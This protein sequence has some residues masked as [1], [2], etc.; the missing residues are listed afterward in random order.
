M[1]QKVTTVATCCWRPWKLLLNQ[2]RHPFE[3]KV[4]TTVAQV[5]ETLTLFHATNIIYTGRYS[6][7]ADA[8]YCPF[9]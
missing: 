1:L 4:E 8:T 6:N 5:A 7:Y 2:S 3:T 9:Y